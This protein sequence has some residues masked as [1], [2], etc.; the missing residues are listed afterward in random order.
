MKI[1]PSQGAW[2]LLSVALLASLSHALPATKIITFDANAPTLKT[3]LLSTPVSSA[4]SWST[5]LAPNARGGWNFITQLYEYKSKLPSE[6]VVLDLQ[7]GQYSTLER[8]SGQITN[9]NYQY[10]VQMRAANGRIF[11]SEYGGQDNVVSYYDPADEKVKVLGQVIP[12]GSGDDFIYRWA[13]GPDGMLYGST[14]AKVNTL[15][16]VVRINPETLEHKVLGEVGKERMSYSYGYYLAIDSTPSPGAPQGWV[17]VAVGQTPWEMAALNIATGEQKILATRADAGWMNFTLRPEGIVGNLTTGLRRPDAKTDR[18]WLVDGQMFPYEATYDA[19]QL[20]FQPRNVAPKEGA[21]KETPELDTTQLNADAEGIGRVFWRPAGSKDDKAWKEAQFKVGNAAPI[22]IETLLALPDGTL[23][24]NAQQYH[25]FFRYDPKTHKSTF[26]G[27]HGPSGGQRTV[28]NG[29]AYITGYPRSILYVYDPTRPWTSNLRLEA[30]ADK[31]AL[32]PDELAA[33]NPRKLGH[34]ANLTDTHYAYFL[35]PSK[36]GRLYFGG[37]RERTGTGGG[38]GWY[39]PQ[40]NNFGGHHENLS[41]LKPRGMV[42]LDELQRVVFSGE[43][44]DD[45]AKP[46]EKPAEAQLVIYDMELKE[47]ER[48]TVKPGLKNTGRLFPAAD[49]NRIIGIADGEKYIYRY[50]VTQKKLLDWIELP[51]KVDE[52]TRRLSD[53]SLW[54]VSGSTLLRLDPATMQ[55]KT[56]GKLQAPNNDPALL[57]STTSGKLPTAPNNLI[58]QGDDLFFTN[59]AELYHLQRV[60]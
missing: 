60:D 6:Y 51:D 37:R 21:L 1:Q 9:S 12:E 2:C 35:L 52:I 15:P 43:L 53:G 54:I 7:S 50:D 31:N 45:P 30:A 27:A 4:R 11:F 41:F 16:T 14:Q 48:Q 33:L 38:V 34:F 42:V 19:A 39:D 57:E 13:F 55:I 20:P 5:A 26:F 32:K 44:Q 25:G 59:G 47:I 58:W 22:A 17:Y 3:E 56:I 23:L 18:F 24:G 10:N 8:P 46:H 40:T 36:N 49:K 29:L 28:M